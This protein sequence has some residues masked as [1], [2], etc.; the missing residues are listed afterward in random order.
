MVGDLKSLYQNVSEQQQKQSKTKQ[1]RKET[2]KPYKYSLDH[3]NIA[4]NNN[5]LY[6]FKGTCQWIVMFLLEDLLNYET[7]TKIPLLLVLS[8]LYHISTDA[9]SLS[10]WV[11]K[12]SK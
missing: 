8:L 2:K 4:N 3:W 9:D 7:K 5:S 1:T 11:S 6:L 10:C 12:G